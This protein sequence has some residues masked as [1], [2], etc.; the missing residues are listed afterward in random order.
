MKKGNFPLSGKTAGEGLNKKH[1]AYSAGLWGYL[2]ILPSFAGVCL[3]QLIPYLRSLFYTFTQGIVTPRFVGLDNFAGLL[4]DPLFLQ[5]AGN[6][7]L[8]LFVGGVF[9]L[10]LSLFVS[11]VCA[12]ARFAWQRW[13]IL[14]PLVVPVASLALG[15]Q[16]VF[17]A[18]GL[19]NQILS[20][21]GLPARDFL[22][23]EAAFPL[24]VLLYLL[25]N[26]GYLS[27]IL[28]DAIQRFPQE[29]K[30]NYL[31]DSN[32]ET[33]YVFSILLPQLKSTVLF[34]SIVAVS[35]SFLMF[36]AIYALYG[37]TPPG[38]LYMLQHFMNRNFYQLNYQRLSTAAFLTSFAMA[39]LIVFWLYT[40][41]RRNHV[42]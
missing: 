7:F 39:V 24:M 31:L 3:F 10:A 17:G 28:L 1:K 25:K 8:F 18:E 14:L 41:R 32:S 26:A 15:W 2:L 21:L 29:Q 40:R 19:I 22:Y 5:A 6:T 42:E 16:S 36:R 37:D 34:C 20:L 30:D 9:L 35:N 23:G 4:S 12:K 38:R 33:G 11:I 13:A 27:I